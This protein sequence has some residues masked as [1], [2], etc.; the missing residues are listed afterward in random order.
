MHR[1][2]TFIPP[3]FCIRCT[4]RTIQQIPDC[5]NTVS[6]CYTNTENTRLYEYYKWLLWCTG[7][8]PLSLLPSAFDNQLSKY[9]Q[10]RQIQGCTNTTNTYTQILPDAQA[11]SLHPSFLLHSTSNYT[12]ICKYGKYKTVQ[13]LWIHTQKYFLMHRSAAFCIRQPL[14]YSYL[15]IRQIQDCVNTINTYTQILPDAQASSIHPSF[16]SAFDNQLYLYLQIRQIHTHKYFLMFR[17]A[18]FIP[19]SLCIRPPLLYYANTN[20]ANTGLCRYYKYYEYFAIHKFCIQPLHRCTPLST[21]LH[22]TTLYC[23]IKNTSKNPN[24]TLQQNIM[25]WSITL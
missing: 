5:K 16:L 25:Q 12:C 10:I 11:S 23:I 4:I 17:P 15:Q 19:P 7:Q 14:Q 9:L 24:I 2:E 18:A 3:S 20:T 21:A 8:Q 1:P 13:I 6:T 22:W